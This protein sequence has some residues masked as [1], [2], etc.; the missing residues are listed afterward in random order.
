MQGPLV[1]SSASLEQGV[2]E[3]GARLPLLPLTWPFLHPPPQ[4]L[5]SWEQHPPELFP[6]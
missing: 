4:K 6:R 1:L 2:A 5:M 3:A